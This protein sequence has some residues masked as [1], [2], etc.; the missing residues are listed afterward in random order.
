MTANGAV[1]SHPST[2]DVRRIVAA[3]D[4]AGLPVAVGGSAILAAHGLIDTVRDWD[5]ITHGEAAVVEAALERADVRWR[6]MPGAEPPYATERR[7][8][9][10]TADHEIDVL[11]GFA[12]WDGDR[13]VTVPVRSTRTWLGLPIADP[14]AWVTAYRCMGRH[15]RVAQLTTLINGD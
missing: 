7:Y 11:V 13:V 3:L 4:A 9:V 2:D 5:V 8:V 6:H 15:A 10:S 1:V 12:V 14:D